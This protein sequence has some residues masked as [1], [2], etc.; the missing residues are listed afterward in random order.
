VTPKLTGVLLIVVSAVAGVLAGVFISRPPWSIPAAILLAVSAVSMLVGLLW[1]FRKSWADKT[2]P[3][4]PIGEPNLARQ[5]KILFVT[6]IAMLALV[7]VV[8]G[9]GIWLAFADGFDGWRL[10]QCGFW[11]LFYTA[12][13]VTT[14]QSTRP[15]RLKE[16]TR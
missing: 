2:W 11:A 9:C 6:A 12:F 10:V 1:L 15:E 8:L 3:P 4:G 7:P 13:G 5:R 14:L 16:G